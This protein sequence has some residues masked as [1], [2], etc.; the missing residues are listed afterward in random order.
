MRTQ[1]MLSSPTSKKFRVMVA[2]PQASTTK[3]QKT[4]LNMEESNEDKYLLLVA[5]GNKITAHGLNL[6][7]KLNGKK[8]H[9]T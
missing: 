8:L 4:S 6:D 3:K 2:S 5:Q 1:I 9:Q 7:A